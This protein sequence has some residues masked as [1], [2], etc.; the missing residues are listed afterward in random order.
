MLLST[1]KETKAKWFGNSYVSAIIKNNFIEA[2]ARFE[3]LGSPLPGHE[4]TA[5]RGLPNMYLTGRFNN[6]ELTLGDF[7]DQF[8]S[9]MIFRTYEE[10]TLGI[11]NSV[12]GARIQISPFKGLS[13][14]ALAG[15]QR[16]YFDR[17]LKVFNKDRG[18]IYGSDLELNIDQWVRSMDQSGTR[19]MLG[20][21]FV[22]KHE[23]DEDIYVGVGE[24]RK[25]LNLPLN[26]PIMGARLNFQ[27]GGFSLYGE[28]GYKYNDPSADNG[29]IYHD[30]QAALLSASYSM[31]GMSMLLQ[32]KRSENF[33]FRSQRGAQQT[34]LFI[35]HLPAF[36]QAHTYSLAAIYPYATQPLGE[37]AFQGEFA[38]QFKRNTALGGRYGTHIKLNASH[39]RGLDQ[40]WFSEDPELLMGT[41][42]YTSTFFGMGDLYYSDINLEISKKLTPTYSFSFSYLNQISNNKVLQSSASHKPENI[43]AHIFIYD[44]K[45]RLSPKVTLRT[46]LQYLHTKQDQGDW[47]YGLAEL[48]LL[49][50]FMFTVSEQYNIG[51][52]K[53]HYYMGSVAYTRGSHRFSLAYG[54]TRAG[55][56][57]SGGVCR[58][59][60][61]T[62]GF[63]FSYNANI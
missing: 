20:A 43:Y 29:Y 41:D 7:Y 59:I 49:P 31:K 45:H 61:E 38:Y 32:A 62:Q 33:S 21:S 63:Y 9:G 55:M 5:G 18:S 14:K 46:E 12:R 57:C 23:Q 24:D 40:K 1:E 27:K 13:F 35:N 56:N 52:T 44:G 42:G 25:R 50:S 39:V 48:S 22:T 58:L 15:Q 19:L 3:E 28:Y 6:V 11:D 60:P 36:T 2:G 37:W 34:A 54:K 17:T 16:N 8:G 53:E 4:A 30:G 26:I 10:R 51:E 47:I